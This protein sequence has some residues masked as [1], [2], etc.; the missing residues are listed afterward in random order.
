MCR[1]RDSEVGPRR[2]GDGDNVLISGDECRSDGLAA[3]FAASDL[4]DIVE[5]FATQRDARGL[6][7][8]LVS[9]RVEMTTRPAD[10]EP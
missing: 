1:G 10:R 6:W 3:E 8:R 4:P 7:A 9:P 5:A 2:R